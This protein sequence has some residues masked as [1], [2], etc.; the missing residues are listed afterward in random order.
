MNKRIV[1]MADSI[2][3]ILTVLMYLICAA[4]III[5][6]GMIVLAII[7]SYR[8]RMRFANYL[9]NMNRDEQV[10][11]GRRSLKFHS[12]FLPGVAIGILGLFTALAIKQELIAQYI[13]YGLFIF[14]LIM[15]LISVFV[16]RL[17]KGK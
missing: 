13:C 10:Q 9:R 14:V 1:Y 5:F 15:S 12:V 4:T 2:E 7:S 3:L 8:S 16:Y 17:P 11:F 6:I